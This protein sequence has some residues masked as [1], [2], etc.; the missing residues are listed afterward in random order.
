MGTYLNPGNGRF[1]E[2][3]NTE[4]YVDK[5][6]MISYLN[7]I[8]KTERKYV[9]VSRPRRFGKSIAANMLC[10]YYGKGDSRAL[11]DSSK[12]ADCDEWDAVFRE[13][14]EDKEGQT[15]Y[16]DF[17]R[18]WLKDKSY[19]ALAY[20]TGILPIKKYGKHSALNMFDEYSIISPMQLAPYTGFTE[21]EVKDL[22]CEYNL[23]YEDVSDWYD[24]YEISTIIPVGMR[25]KYRMGEY[26]KEKMYIYSPLSVVKAVSTGKIQNY[27]NKTEN[28][29]AL[30]EYIRLNLDG[31]MDAVVLLMDDGRVKIDISTYQNDM[32]SF[33]GRDDVLIMLIHLG[34]LSYDEKTEEVFIPNKEVLAEFRSSTK[35]DKWLDT[36]ASEARTL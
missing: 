28:Y 27:W 35:S 16:L 6:E 13:R 23:Q 17:L 15:V 7:K 9:S 8:L 14:K 10:A 11:F 25:G 3:I 33:Y 19:V 31:L 5:T 21:E 32:I 4:I 29:E 12:L 2:I 34:Y 24:G 1:E 30:A 26:D 20:M 22:C 36:F 18:D